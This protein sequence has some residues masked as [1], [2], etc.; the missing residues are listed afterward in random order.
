MASR[1]TSTARLASL[2][3]KAGACAVALARHC[4]RTIKPKSESNTM[5]NEKDYKALHAAALTLSTKMMA[6]LQPG[7][8]D[9]LEKATKAG[10]VVT[11]QLGPL[12]DCQRIE[13]LLRE[14]EGSTHILASIGSYP[15]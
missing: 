5:T 8:I 3:D 13:L 11:L 6:T 7:E 2:V 14:R 12:P 1:E 4:G 10:A 15:C 9:A